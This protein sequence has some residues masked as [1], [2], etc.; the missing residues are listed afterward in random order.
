MLR[1]RHRARADHNQLPATS[2]PS[3]LLLNHHRNQSRRPPALN[4]SKGRRGSTTDRAPIAFLASR[5]S[6]LFRSTN[7]H[8][9]ELTPRLHYPN[10]LSRSYQPLHRRGRQKNSSPGIS[11]LRIFWE[12]LSP[13]SRL[14][15]KDHRRYHPHHHPVLTLNLRPQKGGRGRVN[16]SRRCSHWGASR[17]NPATIM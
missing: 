7:P 17:R 15:D 1:L 3:H 8:R 9:R 10:L 6:N 11:R 14:G 2:L 4:K 12:M 16:K 5:V 13:H